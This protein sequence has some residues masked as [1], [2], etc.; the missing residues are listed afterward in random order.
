MSVNGSKAGTYV[1]PITS[2]RNMGDMN[3]SHSREQFANGNG[4]QQNTFAD[5]FKSANANSERKYS[6]IIDPNY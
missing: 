6:F 5:T 2:K 3:N 4:K 1:M